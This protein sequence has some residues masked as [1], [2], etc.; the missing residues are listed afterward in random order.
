MMRF[1]VII[2]RHLSCAV[3]FGSGRA[4]TEASEVQRLLQ[5]VNIYHASDIL[6]TYEINSQ[7]INR[8]VE[9]QGLIRLAEEDG[10]LKIFIPRQDTDLKE[11]FSTYLPKEIMIYLGISGA[12]S[13]EAVTGILHAA[14]ER[15][16]IALDRRGILRPG[17]SRSF[18]LLPADDE[19]ATSYD[20][21]SQIDT[22]LG[23]TVPTGNWIGQDTQGHSDMIQGASNGLVS[24]N[25]YR[26]S[27]VEQNSVS[28]LTGW[29]PRRHTMG[30]DSMREVNGTRLSGIALGMTI[31]HRGGRPS[32]SEIN[33][34]VGNIEARRQA[35][36]EHARFSDTAAFNLI[37]S[38]SINTSLAPMSNGTAVVARPQLVSSFDMS[39][40]AMALPAIAATGTNVNLT[41]QDQVGPWGFYYPRGVITSSLEPAVRSG[42]RRVNDFA[43]G[44]L[45]EQYIVTILKD[46]VPGFNEHFHWTSTLREYAGLPPYPYREMTDLTFPDNDG[47]L[48]RLLL[49]WSRGGMVPGWLVTANMPGP[50]VRPTFW[51]EVKTTPG[52][53]ET[54]FYVSNSQYRLVSHRDA[55]RGP[56][57]ET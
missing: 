32:L 30:A 25:F 43:I 37:A 6:T 23:M 39:S 36:I 20:T 29:A 46:K 28:V 34:V 44:F 35:V 9:K 56:D 13:L 22:V 47:H 33:N 7:G 48:S 42:Q 45:G 54:P 27:V 17:A 52:V 14:L 11:I 55:L 8:R 41:S 21:Y 57:F 12:N 51:L 18:D 15:L 1:K 53:C 16:E 10:Q 24:Q 38:P 49:S 31:D 19:T 50:M 3:H 4:R 26:S 2:L 40:V 5:E